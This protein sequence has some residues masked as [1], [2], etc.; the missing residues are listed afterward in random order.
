[1][2]EEKQEENQIR[3]DEPRACMQKTELFRCV[4]KIAKSFALSV[5]MDLG[6]YLTDFH[7]T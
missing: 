4:P 7:K 1:M 5:R 2:S 6:S 3:N